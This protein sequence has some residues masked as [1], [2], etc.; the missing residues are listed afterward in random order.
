AFSARKTL[1]NKSCD[2]PSQNRNHAR[3][4]KIEEVQADDPVPIDYKNEITK[5]DGPL[6]QMPIAD[7]PIKLFSTFAPTDKNFKE[8]KDGSK[9]LRISPGDRLVIVGQ[10][11]ICVRKGEISLL[12]ATLT[13]S[14]R[15]RVFASPT[16]SLPVIRCSRESFDHAELSLYPFESGFE[17]LKSISPLFGSFLDNIPNSAGS[18]LEN[19]FR[20]KKLSGF[21]I[22]FSSNDKHQ[23]LPFQSLVSPPEWNLA[24]SN[25]LKYSGTPSIVFVCGPKSAGKSTFAKLLINR[26]ISGSINDLA[27]T[28]VVLLDL[29]PGQP[30]YSPPGQLSLIHIKELNLGPSFS[31][32]IC[33][34]INKCI[35]SHSIGAVS[36]TLDPDFYKTCATNLFSE[37]LRIFATRSPKIPLVINT[38]GWVL[39]TGLEILVEL[40]E[41][42]KPTIVIYMSQ[43]GPPEVVESLQDVDKSIKF[44]SLPSQTSENSS[45]TAAHLRKMLYI[46]YFHLNSGPKNTLAWDIQPITSYRPWEIRY[47][48]D[49]PGIL[50]IVCYGE[51]PPVCLLAETLNGCLVSIVVVDELDAVPE[52]E[53][54]NLNPGKELLGIHKNPMYPQKFHKEPNIIRT[55]EDLPYFNPKKAITLDPEKSHCIGLALIRGIDVTRRRLQVITPIS[56]NII[57]R[58]QEAEKSIVLVHGKLE[59]PGWAYTEYIMQENM[60][61]ESCEILSKPE[62]IFHNDL[63]VNNTDTYIALESGLKEEQFQNFPWVERLQG[64]QGRSVGSFVWRVRRDL[65]KPNDGPD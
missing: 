27:T 55:P 42:I 46:S 12:G 56:P 34:S 38:P 54:G 2:T 36:P 25:C 51:Y 6:E 41:K 32:P 16:H 39:G 10:Y 29:D 5:E 9:S 59:T 21:Q 48:G 52:L 23:K 60:S 1:K 35:R 24:I 15:Y 64:H 30:E 33:G 26:F 13:H 18:E 14:K 62:Q 4:L 47:S 45:R 28:G 37:Y 63:N 49:S 7:G 11:E 58:L 8:F 43:D 3:I 31:H 22:L 57:E 53:I 19:L 40:I 44:V 50:G 20:K 17:E 65:G 61:E